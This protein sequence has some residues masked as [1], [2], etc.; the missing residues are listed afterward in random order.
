MKSRM[1]VDVQLV[2][3]RVR[4]A[5]SLQLNYGCVQFCLDQS[6]FH[7]PQGSCCRYFDSDQSSYAITRN[8]QITEKN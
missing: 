5:F 3:K 2:I 7:T 6:S 8:S 1:Q 4:Q